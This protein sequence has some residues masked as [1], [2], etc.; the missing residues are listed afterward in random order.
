MDGNSMK[1]IYNQTF[2]GFCHLKTLRLMNMGI[3]TIEKGAFCD[4]SNLSYLTLTGNK[5]RKVPG[6]LFRPLR[7]L[8]I[9][10]L[11]QNELEAL[12]DLRGLPTAMLKLAL[13]HNHLTNISALSEMGIKSVGSLRLW[14]NNITS[15]PKH[16]IQ[17]IFVY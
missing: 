8:T 10:S 9:L 13:G 17:K 2:R 4:L 6:E 1:T 14:Y 7:K 5:L 12:T 16:I 15:L 11:E 3:N